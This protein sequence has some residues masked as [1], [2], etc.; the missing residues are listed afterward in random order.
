MT[1]LERVDLHQN[2][3]NR[4]LFEV[5]SKLS[6]EVEKILRETEPGKSYWGEGY[7]ERQLA[8]LRTHWALVAR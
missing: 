7:V 2:C 8:A 4:Q 6:E 1:R 3:I 5:F